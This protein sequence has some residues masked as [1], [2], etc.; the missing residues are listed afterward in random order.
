MA[1]KKISDA[2][3]RD[4]DAVAATDV[5]EIEDPNAAVY[6]KIPLSSLSMVGFVRSAPPNNPPEGQ[7]LI[8]GSDGTDANYPA[9]SIFIT[10]TSGGV[11]KTVTLLPFSDIPT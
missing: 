9:G 11:T 4:H 10:A 6:Y 5:L 8:W 1:D 2:A 3:E 7:Y